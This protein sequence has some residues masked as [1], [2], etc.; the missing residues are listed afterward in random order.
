[1]SLRI[2]QIKGDWW[3]DKDLQTGLTADQREFYVGLWQIADD[4]GYLEWDPVRIG[5]ALYPFRASGR[6]ERQI[7]QWAEALMTLDRES[8][9]RLVLPCGHARVPKMPGHQRLAGES[10]QVR[11]VLRKHQECLLPRVPASPRESP[12]IP[13]T[14]RNGRGTVEGERDGT[15]VALAPEGAARAPSE[16]RSKVPPPPSTH[17]VLEAARKTKSAS[18]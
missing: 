1:V 12:L 11:T 16:F 8:P 9:H 4:A 10:K 7:A 3:L 2:R 14:E 17:A 18:R 6:R 5:A 15:V 13:D